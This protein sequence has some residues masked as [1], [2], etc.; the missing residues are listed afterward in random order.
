[1]SDQKEGKVEDWI[2]YNNQIRVQ[3]ISYWERYNWTNWK[4]WDEQDWEDWENGVKMSKL[5]NRACNI[6]G[7]RHCKTVTP[8]FR[9]AI[10]C[11]PASADVIERRQAVDPEEEMRRY[12]MTFGVKREDIPYNYTASSEDVGIVFDH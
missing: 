1:M 3:D 7:F 8:S 6:C 2:V 4:D 11:V 9:Y 5:S 10:N 12:I